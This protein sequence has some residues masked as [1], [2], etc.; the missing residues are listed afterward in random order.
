MVMREK[1]LEHFRHVYVENKDTVFKIVMRYS[2]VDYDT[3]QDITQEVFVKLYEHFDTYTEEYLLQWLIVTAKNEAC[4]YLRR[5]L[6]EV[7]NEEVAMKLLGYQLLPGAEETVFEK[8]NVEE[9]IH[10][11]EYILD[12]L[13]TTNERWYEAVMLVY[14]QEMKQ[15]D[16]ADKMGISLEVLQSVLYRARKWVRE[17]I[18]P[19]D[20]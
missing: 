3:A 4:S 19:D 5:V 20:E 14:C 8:I 17:H 13:Y 18:K 16:V 1:N 6:R 11:S 7:P 10:R 2:N 15:K 12:R 9:R